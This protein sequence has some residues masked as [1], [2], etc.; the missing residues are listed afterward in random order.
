MYDYSSVIY[1]FAGAV[2]SVIVVILAAVEIAKV[3]AK[4]RQAKWLKKAVAEVEL[5]ATPSWIR[6]KNIRRIK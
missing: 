5:E 6:R 2:G 4:K 3:V 1:M